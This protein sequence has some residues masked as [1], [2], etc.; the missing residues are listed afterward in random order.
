MQ[1]GCGR[2][3]LERAIRLYA[4]VGPAFTLAP[5]HARHVIGELSAKVEVGERGLTRR[6]GHRR[7]ITHD[8][9]GSGVGRHTLSDGL[10]HFRAF[11]MFW[12][13][14]AAGN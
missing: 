9:K 10:S 12:P 11:R 14:R 4:P 3:Q 2:V 8:V 5:L 13:L 1:H 7:G 6:V